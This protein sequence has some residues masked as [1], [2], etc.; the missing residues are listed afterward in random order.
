LFEI[1]EQTIFSFVDKMD[2]PPFTSLN[3]KYPNSCLWD[4]ES[5]LSMRRWE[6]WKQRLRWISERDELTE[7]TRHEALMIEQLMQ[8]IE[9]K[10]REQHSAE[11]SGS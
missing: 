6:F 7:R 1:A 8:N 3:K 11:N 10:S 2:L 4:G 9:Q 5:Q